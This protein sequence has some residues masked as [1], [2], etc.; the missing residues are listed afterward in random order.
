MVRLQRWQGLSLKRWLELLPLGSQQRVMLMLLG[1]LS[2]NCRICV[3]AYT[4][5]SRISACKR[6][7][8]QKK[9]MTDLHGL[10]LGELQQGE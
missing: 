1:K 10:G 5:A 2:R 4:A 3:H 8:N 7:D 6:S 9:T